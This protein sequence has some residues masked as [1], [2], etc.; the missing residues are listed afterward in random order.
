MF[1]FFSKL[2]AKN[3]IENV[4]SICATSVNYWVTVTNIYQHQRER[5]VQV[6]EMTFNTY[7]F[8]Y[9]RVIIVIF[10]AAFLLAG[11]C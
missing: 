4:I 2:C 9:V 1:S 11:S 10:P 3:N 6:R 8:I 7:I 5:H